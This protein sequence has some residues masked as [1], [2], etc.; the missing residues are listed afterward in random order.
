MVSISRESSERWVIE[1]LTVDVF[2]SIN[3]FMP[4]TNSGAESPHA[5]DGADNVISEGKR[6]IFLRGETPGVSAGR[7][8]D[9]AAPIHVLTLLWICMWYC[10]V[11]YSEAVI[12]A[13]SRAQYWDSEV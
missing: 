12:T 1:H 4:V 11:T 7:E 13:H 3:R 9:S 2:K 8:S 5:V 10:V 6:P